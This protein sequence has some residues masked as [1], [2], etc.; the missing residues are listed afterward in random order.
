MLDFLEV[1][2]P[3]PFV[4][5]DLACGPGAIAQRL[6]ARVPDAEV[7]GVDTDPVLLAL[8]EG[9]LGSLGGRMTWI[10]DDLN[11]PAWA[12]RLASRLDGRPLDAVLSSTALHWPSPG[13]LARVY[14]DL[15]QLMRPG[16]VFMNADHMAF[17]PSVETIRT[18]ALA[19]KERRRV[20]ARSQAGAEDWDAWWVALRQEPGLADLLAEREERFSWRDGV[21]ANAS[22]E[23]QKGAL[24]VAGFREVDVVWQRL[25]SRVLMAI[26]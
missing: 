17:P 25:D 3:R 7:M 23:F 1:S 12:E 10:K 5:L 26:R 2:V 18:A 15:G 20:A 16:G 4:A 24:F 14:R 6:L 22:L 9:A 21:W 19:L 13:T 11:D 8:G